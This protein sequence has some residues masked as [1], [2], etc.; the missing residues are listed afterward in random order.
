MN[1]EVH[2]S[3]TKCQESGRRKLVAATEVKPFSGVLMVVFTGLTLG[4]VEKLSQT[5]VQKGVFFQESSGNA[6]F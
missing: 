5:L 4:I 1:L 2:K 3:R 6:I